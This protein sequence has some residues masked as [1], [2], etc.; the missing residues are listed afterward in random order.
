VS[1]QGQTLIYE[2]GPW[3]VHLGRRE[4]LAS[5]VPVPIGARA[6]EIVEV[7]V[8]SANELVT[9]DDLMGRIWP[10]AIVGENTLQVHISAIRKALGRDRAMLKTASGRGYRLLGRWT[11]RQP[12]ARMQIVHPAPA[13]VAVEPVQNNLPLSAADLIGRDAAVHHLRDL[14]SAYRIVTLTGPGGIGKTRLGLEVARGL[15]TDFGSGVWYVELASLSDANLVAVATAGVLGLHLAGSD[16]SPEALARAIGGR[17]LLLLID[18]CEHVIDA[19]AKVVE[20]VVRLCPAASV[21]A[22]SREPMR[23]E[24]ECTYRVPPLD[25]PEQDVSGVGRDRILETSAVQLFIARMTAWESGLEH[26]RELAAI[27]AICRR[28][29]GIPLAIEFAAA[30]ATTLGLEG[31]LSRLDD[32]F[33]LLTSGRRTALPKHRTLRATLDWSHEL[34]SA[35]ERVLLRRLAIFSTGF[36]LDAAC[37]VTA[38]SEAAYAE[39]ADGIANLVAKSLVTVDNAV[40]VANFRL[41]ETIRAYAFEKLT[42]AGEAQQ[43][44]RRHAE[45]YR[46]LLERIEDEREARAAHL[47]DLGNARAALEWCFGGNGDIEIGVGLA[48]AAAPVFLAMSLLTECHRWSERAILALADIAPGGR[49]EM[50]LQAALGM[51]LMITRGES[52]AVRVALN[53]SLAI[54]EERSDATTQLKLLGPLR[55]FHARIADF[56]TALHYA[57]R[58]SEVART[59]ADPVAITLA[60]SMLGGSLYFTGDLPGARIEFEAALQERTGSRRTSSTYLGFGGHNIPGVTLAAT[61]WLLGH[62]NKAVEHACQTIEEASSMDHPVTLSVVLIW[63]IS[64]FLWT[65]D[66]LRAEEHVNRFAARAETYSMGPYL[67]VGRGFKGQLAI[68]RGDAA[69]GVDSL[70][71]SLKNLHAARYELLT[72]P[73]NISLVQGL[74]AIGRFSDAITL[75][76]DTIRLIE[77]NGDHC[78][79][80]EALRVRGS[81][82]LAMPRPD[83]D[84]A[85]MCFRRSLELS[86]RQSAR[87]WELRTGIDLARLLAARGQADDARALLRP[88]FE[89][90]EEGFNTADLKSAERLLA[91]LG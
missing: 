75:I 27:A 77:A 71:D 2:S 19:A 83:S 9:K 70:Q 29:D 22:T 63:G 40:V 24:G 47:A 38:S 78:Y 56:K 48:A 42:E 74:A 41:L 79:M 59:L 64:V 17:K 76:D 39:I 91:T 28:L 26:R 51:S 57:I 20:T 35:P 81:V 88:V 30:R 52:E 15:T 31:V 25:F 5:G 37:A 84:E 34:L 68:L 3:Q 16:I 50:Q 66:L 10:G 44:A 43:F 36:S 60:H 46:G 58:C 53:R 13:P 85:E 4:L 55:M 87:A 33:A 54:A 45:Y 73:F 14:L 1:E 61:M 6:F 23:I 69:G 18:N 72:T 67:A 65:G 80:P 82:L 89:Q 86:R 32:R 21:L 8:R 49:E 11:T 90:F 7:L 12:A 62:P